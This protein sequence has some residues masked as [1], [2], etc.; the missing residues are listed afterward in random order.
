M[1]EPDPKIRE[2]FRR[3]ALAVQTIAE[4]GL[5]EV[6]PRSRWSACERIGG[7]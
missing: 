2:D 7:L 4:G 5:V 6:V 1:D 3:A